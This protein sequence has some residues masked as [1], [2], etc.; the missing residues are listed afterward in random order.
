TVTETQLDL[1]PQVRPR[2]RPVTGNAMTPAEKQARYRARKARKSVTVTF[3]RTDFEALDMFVR[4]IRQGH[5]VDLDPAALE[6]VYKAIRDAAFFQLA[7][8]E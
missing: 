4:G 1:I 7:T 2:G 6:G 3:N 8:K 5:G